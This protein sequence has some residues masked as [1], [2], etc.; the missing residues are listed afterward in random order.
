MTLSLSLLLPPH[1]FPV[2]LSAVDQLLV[3]G[4]A[5]GDPLAGPAAATQDMGPASPPR[6]CLVLQPVELP[7]CFSAGRR[8]QD[9]APR[10]DWIPPTMDLTMLLLA[11][12]QASNLSL[13]F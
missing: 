7:V 5:E 4:E 2:F 3:G 11:L 13:S 6:S 1:N 9:R 8:R 10:P 12:K